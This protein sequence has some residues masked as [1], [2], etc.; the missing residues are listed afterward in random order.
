MYEEAMKAIQREIDGLPNGYISTKVIKGKE[1]HYLQYRDKETN[2]LVSKY[3]PDNQYEIIRGQLRRKKELQKELTDLASIAYATDR[4]YMSVPGSGDNDLFK[5][6]QTGSSLLEMADAAVGLQKRDC[7]KELDR[8]LHSVRDPRVCAL[9]GLRRTGKTTLM[10]QAILS[11]STDELS[12]AAYIMVQH[13]NRM[14]DVNACLETLHSLGYKYVFID[15]ITQLDDF[16]DGSAFLADKYAAMG[17]RIVLSGTHSLGFMLTSHDQLFDRVYLIH[18]TWISFAEHSRLFGTEDVDDYLKLGGVLWTGSHGPGSSENNTRENVFS[19][20]S[21]TDFYINTAIAEN[22]Q[23]SLR[24]WHDGNSF[25]KLE[26]LYDA[27]ELTSAITRIIEDMNHRFAEKVITITFTKSSNLSSTYQIL[28]SRSDPLADAI[29]R[30]DMHAIVEA[31]RHRLKILNKNELTVTVTEDHATEIKQYLK[32]LEFIAEVPVEANYSRREN[33]EKV[34][35]TQPG[36]RYSQVEYLITSI[37]KDGVYAGLSEKEKSDLIKHILD[38][39]KGRMLEELVLFE[40]MNRIG[41]KAKAF[42]YES[43]I[44]EVDMVVYYKDTDTCNL[45]EI[46]H[47]E[48]RNSLQLTHLLN[49]DLCGDIEKVFGT[50]SKKYL[51]YRGDD[52]LEENGIQYLNIATFL[53]RLP[54]SVLE[55]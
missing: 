21:A 2:K 45:Y 14:G 9:Y 30:L 19:S 25:R 46:K 11:M 13:G 17:M 23:H 18:T 12:R 48:K 7:Y 26:E 47:S 22:I 28:R 35:I 39:A 5:Y 29:D 27:N 1:R 54:E 8:Y 43:D 32:R 20:I 36:L 50:I 33:T 53:K 37:E 38:N 55:Q 6:V 51:L 31:L 41:D 24:C 4:A 34:L 52:F 40:T 44:G 15:E 10:Y 16:I 49:K 42:K 3:I